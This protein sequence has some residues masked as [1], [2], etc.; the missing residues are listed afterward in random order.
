M[1]Q[2]QWLR[3]AKHDLKAIYD[4]ISH[5]SG[6]YAQRQIE[7]VKEKTEILK[8]QPQAGKVVEEMNQPDIRELVEGNYRIVYRIISQHRIHILMVHHGARDLNQRISP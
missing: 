2:I 5:D 6:K 3:E 1:V 4:Y 8:R 7:R